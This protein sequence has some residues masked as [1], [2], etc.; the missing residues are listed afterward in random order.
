MSRDNAPSCTLR[1]RQ[2]QF[3]EVFRTTPAGT[4]CPNFY[5]LAHANGCTF[6]PQCSYC[7]LKSSFWYLDGAQ[8][9]TNTARIMD[10]VRDWI[11][12]DGLESYTLNTGNLSDSLAFEPDRPLMSKLV[13]VFRTAAEAK[14][15]PHC[16]L[17][18]TK[19]GIGD[20][21][22]L[23]ETTPCAN[24]I[25]SFSVNAPDAAAEYET[26]AASAEDRLEAARRLMDQGW[27]VRIRID[28]MIA[29][30]DYAAV[31]EQVRRL[32]P[33]R[34]TLGTLRAEANLWRFV[35]NGL[36]AGLEKPADRH[37]LARYPLEVR[38]GL[39]RPAVEALA[40]VCPVGLC[41]ETEGVWA[42][43]GLDPDAGNCNCGA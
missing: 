6:A 7:Y 37:Q 42:T 16:L 39:Y 30:F 12:T 18:V 15:R 13:E 36:F 20:C 22:P 41:E 9:F 23:F 32:A 21:G 17:L 38:L 35:D 43:L 27:R 28:P 14:G 8:A 11:A 33:E 25:V 19:G 4:V 29:G 5:V 31:I 40:D 34:V 24:V 10:E 2:T 3:V 1:E 26:G